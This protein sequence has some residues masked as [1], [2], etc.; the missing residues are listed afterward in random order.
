MSVALSKVPLLR[1]AIGE[2]SRITALP[3]WLGPAPTCRSGARYWHRPRSAYRK[4]DGVVVVSVWCG[5]HFFVG[6]PR[7]GPY[8]LVDEVPVDERCGTCE[9]RWLGHRRDDGLIFSPRDPFAPPKRCLGN[10]TVPG[11]HRECLLCGGRVRGAYGWWSSGTAQH[12]PGPALLERYRPCPR[13]GWPR[14]FTTWDR[15]GATHTTELVCHVHGCDYR[16]QPRS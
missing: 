6:S 4:P 16:C 9:G 7:H 5:P 1:E 12:A 14:L 3:P 13:H 15:A 10:D 11:N 8:M 2:G